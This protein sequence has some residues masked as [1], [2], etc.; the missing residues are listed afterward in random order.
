[1]EKIEVVQIS[2]ILNTAEQCNEW[3]KL[4]AENEQLKKAILDFGKNP[5]GFDWG[6]LNKI[7]ELEA[8]NER[9]KNALNIAVN[10]V[11]GRPNRTLMGALYDIDQALKEK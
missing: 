10:Y 4:F 7:D 8:E 1:M 5:A 2:P 9:L 3:N 6:V 11:K